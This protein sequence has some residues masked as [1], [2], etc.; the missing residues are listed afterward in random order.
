M[1]WVYDGLCGKLSQQELR[2]LPGQH[3]IPFVPPSLGGQPSKDQKTSGTSSRT[4][5]VSLGM[6][7]ALG[8]SSR[9]GG[10]KFAVL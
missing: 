5:E 6:S 10:V 3:W 8:G 9:G 7:G 4:R 2:P 1:L